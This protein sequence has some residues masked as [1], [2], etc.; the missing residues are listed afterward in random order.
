MITGV[1]VVEAGEGVA[2]AYAGK[3]LLEQGASVVKLEVPG[4]D[5]LR[6][7]SAA[8]PDQP[9]SGTG[10]L[11]SYL[12]AGKQFEAVPPEWADVVVTSSEVPDGIRADAVIVRISAFGGDGPLAGAPANEFTLQGWCGLLSACGTKD[13]PPL[14]MGI[15]H[16]QY[17]TGAMAA[18][19]ALA[20][21]RRGGGI[22]IEVAALE[23]M[24]VALNN[25]PTL[26]RVLTGGAAALSRGGDWP[27]VV[28]CKDGWVGLCIFTGQQWVDFAA[29][30]G[31]PDLSHDDRFMTMR[32]RSQHRP[33]VESVLRPWLAEH[34]AA[35]IHELGGV[36]RVPVA[37]IGNGESVFEMAHLV[38]RKVFRDN[39][40]GFRQ[41]RSPILVRD[42]TPAPVR[43]VGRR[44]Q[45]PLEGITVLDLT[46]FWSGPYA[47]HLLATLGADVLKIESPRRPDG[48]RS[49]TV[50]PPG[51]PNWL[52]FGPTF[53]ASNPAK[54]SV[55]IDFSVPSGRD[56]LLALVERADVFVENFT[57]RVLANANLDYDVL[58]ARQP[59]VIV[60]RLPGFGLNGPWANHSGFAQTMEQSSGIAWLTG[61]PEGEPLVRSTIDPI[62][63]IHAA[64]AVLAALEER[65]RTGEGKQ[66]E[67]P[68][69]EVALNVAAEPAVTW[70]AYGYRMDRQGNRGPR[71]VPQGVYACRGVEQWIALSIE[72]DQQWAAM[73]EQLGRPAW[74]VDARLANRAGRRRA[75]DAI[76][77]KLNAWFANLDRDETVTRLL[78]AGVP[79]APVWDQ[80][81]QDSLPQLVARRFFQPVDHPFAGRLELP[82]I[83]MRSRGLDLR[84]RAA[85]PTIGQHTEDVLREMVGLG[86]EDL[87]LLRRDGAI[88]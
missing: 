8:C 55:A 84:Y 10:A 34:T 14:Q 36:F 27:S 20:G 5:P 74:A 47:T 23:V 79:A 19:G 80:T 12:N 57:P 21:R 32:A 1:R 59:G 64:F 39:P 88:G 24:A 28:R 22:E 37:L 53:H 77:E 13:T 15:G 78:V 85:A 51:A 61:T 30:I 7:W 83:G 87:S 29:M 86:D 33:L 75:H 11:F 54:R 26:Y 63:G 68:M 2:V 17:A 69:I 67:V 25:Y 9:V 48:M 52:E 82:G 38:E 6:W 73:G 18:L 45:R 3:L 58:R 43:P 46:A 16:G 65:Q 40:A 76:D 71:A 72:T 4:G 42:R 66:V 60:V 81:D 31:R 62:E 56:V 70:S 44:R 41:P 49:A 50:A 35:E